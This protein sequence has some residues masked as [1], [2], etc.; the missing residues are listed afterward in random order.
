MCMSLRGVH[1]GVQ[2]RGT[3]TICGAMRK[4]RARARQE[5]AHS[6]ARRGDGMTQRPHVRA[7]PARESVQRRAQLCNHGCSPEENRRLIRKVT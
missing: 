4:K 3:S 7:V 2:G 6:W 5:V 1:N